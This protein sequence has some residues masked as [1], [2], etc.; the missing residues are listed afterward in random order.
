M[1]DINNL[2]KDIKDKFWKDRIKKSIDTILL[3]YNLSLGEVLILR[4]KINPGELYI[5]AVE[6]C[7]LEKARKYLKENPGIPPPLTVIQWRHKKVLFMGSNRAVK[8]VLQRRF[9]DCI[10]VK[11]PNYIR[12]EIISEARLTLKEVIERQK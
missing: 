11:L 1:N 7:N 6:E 12:P 9:P 3:R 8:F 10:I 5:V 4:K 2:L